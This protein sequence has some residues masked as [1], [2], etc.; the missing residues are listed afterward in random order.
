MKRIKARKSYFDN[1]GIGLQIRKEKYEFA[2]SNKL[3]TKYCL[4][5]KLC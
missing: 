2:F 4:F 3:N 1:P 5:A